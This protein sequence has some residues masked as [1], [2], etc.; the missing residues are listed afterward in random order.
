MMTN[1]RDLAR[2][3][4][5]L[6]VPLPKPSADALALL[7][8]LQEA[9]ATNPTPDAQTAI[10]DGK[11]KAFVEFTKTFAIPSVVDAVRRLCALAAPISG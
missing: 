11:V 1:P 4:D 2:A 8:A 7:D 10:L 3:L 6:A 9:A 5:L